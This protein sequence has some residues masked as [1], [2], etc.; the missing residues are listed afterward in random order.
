MPNSVRMNRDPNDL[1]AS[2]PNSSNQIKSMI[3]TPDVA[4]SRLV[5]C[6]NFVICAPKNCTVVDETVTNQTLAP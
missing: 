5:Q 6:M 2:L 1:T 3:V 4:M